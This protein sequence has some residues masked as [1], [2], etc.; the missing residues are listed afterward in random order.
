MGASIA[1]C[2]R[3]LNAVTREDRIRRECVIG[4]LGPRDAK[5]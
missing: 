1:P 4:A 5:G 3:S 2:R